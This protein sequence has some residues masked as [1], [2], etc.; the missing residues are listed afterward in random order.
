MG[1]PAPGCP[2]RRSPDPRAARSARRRSANAATHRRLSPADRSGLPAATPCPSRP[3]IWKSTAR[4]LGSSS[5]VTARPA[6]SGSSSWSRSTVRYSASQREGGVG[7]R[8]DAEGAGAALVAAART[9]EHAQRHPARR[10]AQVERLS[11]RQRRAAARRRG[12]AGLAPV[13]RLA[14]DLDDLLHRVAPDPGRR[15]NPVRLRRRP[16]GR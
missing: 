12:R 16:A 9:G 10:C 2:G 1:A 15:V 13:K 4:T 6:A 11:R 3:G 14:V 8:V 5:R 7:T